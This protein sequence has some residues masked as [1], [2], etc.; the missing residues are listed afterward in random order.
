MKKLEEMSLEELRVAYSELKTAKD[1]S[2][3]KITKLEEDNTKLKA[4]K[5]QLQLYNNKLFAQI[6][7]LNPDDDG[8]GTGKKEE[9]KSYEK[10]VEDLS[11]EGGIF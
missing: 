8:D 11:K 5:E 7:N 4:D 2:D 3:N 10:L 6:P 9:P 1:E